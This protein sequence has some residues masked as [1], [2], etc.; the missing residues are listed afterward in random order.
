MSV[1]RDIFVCQ[2]RSRSLRNHEECIHLIAA[3]S[4]TVVVPGSCS[5]APCLG[6]LDVKVKR[7]TTDMTCHAYTRAR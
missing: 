7:M 4:C 2:Q 6:G 3:R 1:H 5:Q